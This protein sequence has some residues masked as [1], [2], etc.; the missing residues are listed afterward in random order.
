MERELT[1]EE[2]NE[3]VKELE[4]ENNFY[5]CMMDAFPVNV[6]VKD[7][8]CHY[9]ITSKVCDELNGVER[10]GLK[11]KT[12]FDLQSSK[13]IAQ[14]FYDDD[15]NIMRKKEGSFM[16][17]PTLCGDTIKYYQ[18][19]KEPI[20]DEDGTVLGIL[21]MV[22]DPNSEVLTQDKEQSAPEQYLEDYK[23]EN[24]LLLDYNIETDET[25]VLSDSVDFH[26]LPEKF[27]GFASYLEGQGFI[28]HVGAERLTALIDK[29]KNGRS[30]CSRVVMYFD[31]E[32]NHKYALANMTALYDK[33]RK[34]SRVICVLRVIPEADLEMEKKRIVMQEASV[35]FN[36]LLSGAY[37]R[38][39]YV[40]PT[41]DW[42][43]VMK[44]D[45][46]MEIA[47]TGT[48][49]GIKVLW[50]D[51]I[52]KHAWEQFKKLYYD[53]YLLYQGKRPG[54]N[55]FRTQSKIAE[56]V[57][58]WKEITIFAHAT[59]DDARSF[60]VAVA[61]IEDDVREE[62]RIKRH[63]ANKQIID[64]LST[65]VEY[66][67]LE[68]GEHIHRIEA[69]SEL[70]L[71][72]Y[73]KDN[74]TDGFTD[75]EIKII[76]TASAMHDIGKIAISDTILLKPGKL[77]KEEFDNMKE[78]TVKGSEMIRTVASIQDK[79]YARYCYEICRYHHERYDGK[80]YPD[81][82]AGDDIPVAAQI[83]SVADVY[84]A[85]VSKRCYKDAYAKDEAYT[86]IMNGECGTFSD[87]ILHCL[88]QCRNDIEAL[89]A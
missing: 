49:D 66:R 26:D 87:K 4:K 69:L 89:Y 38:I 68:S 22:I 65:I 43:Q 1:Y 55:T 47:E 24:S 18:I 28:D 2:L 39:I 10:G 80:G 50:Q 33:K 35:R 58:R 86:M 83:V 11:G 53:D 77:T 51:L 76:A 64:V 20:V 41:K 75:E 81:G 3:R 79:D 60:I 16:L 46:E 6:F 19:F 56:D 63:D 21:G 74:V 9:S 8:S 52:D 44:N 12:D 27:E 5:K 78:H 48:F 25:M 23:N 29:I 36:D 30:E 31:S 61:D 17:S 32:G 70:L 72:E 54:I 45:T 85:L 7:T 82:L 67:D 88:E 71:K 73:S 34:A 14:S 57:Y 42:Y 59:E 40:S 15:L 37:E 13:E 62:N 84:D